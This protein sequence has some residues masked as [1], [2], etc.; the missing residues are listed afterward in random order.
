[1]LQTKQKINLREERDFGDKLNATFYFIKT[2]FKPLS[3]ALLLY[4]TPVALAAGIF[5]G[6]FQARTLQ[7]M[8]GDT[9]YSTYGEYAFFNQIASVQYLLS[10]FFTLVSFFVLSLAV[11]S[12]MV[13][14]QDEEGE[15]EQATVWEHIKRN[16]VP[17]IYSGVAIAVVTFLSFFLLGFGIY[18]GIVMSL[19]VIVMVRE[20][21][22]FIETVER[23]FY[24]IKGNW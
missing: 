9:T 13:A 15:V 23:C 11:S 1:M 5:S 3:K 14:Y 6:L 16:L 24:L 7:R 18:L 12:F 8:T 4:V 10:M 20:E 2:N 21:L 19:F 17:V 22:G